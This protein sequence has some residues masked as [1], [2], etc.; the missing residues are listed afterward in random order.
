MTGTT[1]TLTPPSTT[2]GIA[3]ARTLVIY[4]GIKTIVNDKIK[5]EQRTRLW[6]LSVPGWVNEIT[7]PN[8]S[9]PTSPIADHYR[10]EVM[11]LG[12]SDADVTHITR[13]ATDI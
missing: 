8:M 12:G 3:M 11:Y 1:L 2:K 6:E 5:S 4:S 9:L 7:L 13:N 10:W